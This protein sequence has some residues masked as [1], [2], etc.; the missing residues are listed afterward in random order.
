MSDKEYLRKLSITFGNTCFETDK[1]TMSNISCHINMVVSY[2]LA[3]EISYR[4]GIIADSM[5]D[6]PNIFKD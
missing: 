2:E 1:N 5:S 4:L 6:N 3:H